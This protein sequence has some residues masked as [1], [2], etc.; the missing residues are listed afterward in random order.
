MINGQ[1]KQKPK[2]QTLVNDELKNVKDTVLIEYLYGKHRIEI[3]HR[4][5]IE[6]NRIE[7]EKNKTENFQI[8]VWRKDCSTFLKDQNWKESFCMA[9]KVTIE[10]LDK[11]MNEFVIRLNLQEDFKDVAG[12]KKH[13]TNHFNKYGL[14]VSQKEQTDSLTDPT[15]VKIKL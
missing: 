12:L 14:I 13:Y 7:K 9:K 2:I 6:E 3:L 1:Y 8:E 15:K 11:S 10:Q 5:R 4:N